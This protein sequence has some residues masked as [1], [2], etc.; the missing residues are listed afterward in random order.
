MAA[1]GSNVNSLIT[2]KFRIPSFSTHGYIPP[3][4]HS[5]GLPEKSALL[6]KGDR[7]ITT[8]RGGDVGGYTLIELL[9]G[10]S[11]M[12][13]I[14]IG[15]GLF[16]RDVFSLNTL[17][18]NSLIAHQEGRKAL[19]IMSA[20]IRSLSPS[21]TGTYAI[22]EAGSAS[23]TF[24]G[25]IDNDGVKERVRYFLSGTVLKRGIV[26]PSGSPLT[27]NPANEISI[28]LIHDIT[29]G[30]TPVF[31]YYDTNYDGTG[32]ALVEP[33]NVLS[34][35]LVKITAIT[36]KD[37]NRAPAPFTMTTQ[38]SLRNLKDNL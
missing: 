27:Y 35:R 18:S 29:N 32:G 3:P 21:S 17:L 28:E 7:V 11:I 22:A 1:S 38:I 16:Q 9:V 5:I 14:M 31:T 19:K 34:V 24:Y 25:D 8:Q 33:I 4:F 15:V 23:F 26:E 13:L 2:M 30:A 10:V 12:T 37:P 36:D 20:E 6:K